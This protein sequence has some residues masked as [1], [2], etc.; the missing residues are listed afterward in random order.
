MTEETVRKEEKKLVPVSKKKGTNNDPGSF[1]AVMKRLCRDKSAVVALA[2]TL[3]YIAAAV[4]AEGYKAWC[5]AKKIEPVYMV[6]DHGNRY[7][8]P[9]WK[10]PM[11]TDYLGRDVFLRGLFASKT[12]VKVG[13]VASLLS[14]LFG[15]FL[16]LYAGYY[17]GKTDDAVVWIYSTFASMPSL[18]FILAFALLVTKGFLWEPLE[19]AFRFVALL[20]RT[21][22]GMLAVYLG[23]GL[24]GW[25]SLCRVVR[26]ETLRLRDTPY[27]Q[28]SRVL[29][30]KDRVIL[31]RHILPNLMHLVIVYFTMR[32]AYAV[33]TEVI[34][35]YLGL[36]AQFEPSWG[37]M[38]SDGQEKLWRGIYWE[39]GGATLFMFLLVLSLNILGDALRDAL[40]P[41]LKI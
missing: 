25:V 5:D 2:V 1:S 16:G 41:K 27:V 38:I 34:V 10:H 11:G 20:L 33:M 6:Q 29:G 19:K 40:D 15:V 22:P 24:T 39:V 17:G 3:L 7:A 18:L 8:P 9:S 37:I 32:F 28:A 30:Q 12:A 13:V 36:G 14:A 21:E 31:F 23:I 26:A 35:S 4:F